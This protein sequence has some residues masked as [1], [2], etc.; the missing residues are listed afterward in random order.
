MADLGATR[1]VEAADLA[2]AMALAWND[3]PALA[4]MAKMATAFV[5]ARDRTVVAGLDRTLALLP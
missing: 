3:A 2:A 5:E 4:R 1:L